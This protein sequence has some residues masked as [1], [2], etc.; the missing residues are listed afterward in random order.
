MVFQSYAI[1]TLSLRERVASD[2]EPGEGLRLDRHAS[3]V[4]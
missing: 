3:G 4:A 2:S 1:P